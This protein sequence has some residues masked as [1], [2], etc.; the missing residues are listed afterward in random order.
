MSKNL[1]ARYYQ[2]NKERLRKKV[3]KDIKIFSKKKKKKSGN[4]VVNVTKISQK[5]KSKRLL[6]VEKKIAECERCFEKPILK[7]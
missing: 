3:V 6:S 1:S 4:V 7:L 2:E 5:M